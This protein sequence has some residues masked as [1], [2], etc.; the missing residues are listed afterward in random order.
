MAS[1]KIKNVIYIHTHDMGRYIG[2]YGH[3]LSTPNLDQFSKH[4]TLFRQAYCCG[5]TCSPS[6]AGL[7]TGATPH[8]SGMLGLA[9]R[10]FKLRNPQYHLAAYLK[11]LGFVTALCGIQHEFNSAW[12]QMPYEYVV[13]DFSEKGNADSDRHWAAAA[14][15]FLKREHEQPFFLSFGLFY[16]HRKFETAD[17]ASVSLDAIEL[18]QC[19]PDTT[20]V[21]KD[22]AD[23]QHSLSLADECIGLVLQTIQETGHF[24]NSL[25]IVTT[26]HGIAFPNMKCNLKDDGIGVTLM[27]SYPDNPASGTV[28]DALVSHL[29]VY[30][31]ICD[32]LG[33]APPPHL[34]GVSMRPLFERSRHA[35]RDELFSEVT[36]HAAYEPM[37]CIRTQ[38][39]K[40]IRRFDVCRRVLANCDDSPSKSVLMDA[41]WGQE[42]L[43]E[44]EL[45]DLLEDPQES[46]NRAAHPEYESVLQGLSRKLED[47][48]LATSDPLLQ[49]FV[50]R[51]ECALVNSI[52]SIS[53]SD[54]PYEPI[55]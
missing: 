18:P 50:P 6:R 48:M 38:R 37:R 45:Y 11:E 39:F 51:P 40:L 46:T 55:D 5:P 47:W 44:V 15:D 14:C 53:P 17:T 4:A 33:L 24:Q 49:G 8:E 10:G 41:G 9:H 26:D 7:L 13:R 22:F 12:E 28:S 3:K 43:P 30:P 25:I 20:E 54:G 1:R 52:T 16:P 19:L 23:Y 42:A 21:R 31:T 29:D 32:L 2:C 36:F 35:I 27:L 34:Q